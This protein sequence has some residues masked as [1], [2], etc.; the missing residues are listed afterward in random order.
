MLYMPIS[1]LFYLENGFHEFEFLTLHAVYS[2]VIAIVEVPSG[3]IADVW[4]R[5]KALISGT[6]FG[7]IG[8]S[9]Y[10]FTDGL[11]FFLIAEILLGIGTSLLSGADSALLYD[12]F[13]ESKNEKK[14]I[15][16][17][18]IITALGNFSEVTAA[19][20]VSIIILSTYRQYFQLQ[21]ILAFS[22]FIAALFLTEPKIHEKK[23]TG[24]FKE[25][26]DIVTYTFNENKKLRNILIFS[27]I[28]GFSS[29][30]MAWLAQ[31]ILEK[32]GIK[33]SNFGFSWALLNLLV[34]MGSITA[35]YISQKLHYKA[36]LLFIAIPLSAGFLVIGFNITLW[37]IIPLII[38][39]FV[40]GTAHPILKMYINRLTSSEKR[41][42]VL[43]LRSLIIRIIFLVMG[44]ILGIATEKI[45]LEFGVLLCGIT[46]FIPAVIFYLILLK[47]HNKK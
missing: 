43:S 28:I 37:T 45:S 6:F 8:F 5:K 30:S 15:K 33:E 22:G 13:L 40:R 29:L 19:L 2:G 4:G 35:I 31:P 41:A 20:F 11:I 10:G 26:L 34:M 23:L 17:E 36:T 27:S 44:P 12:S 1:Y 46:V 14:Y 16:H 7:T 47:E 38:F 39:Y 25:I 18:S 32:I 9:V 24:S 21:M 3:Y 42:T